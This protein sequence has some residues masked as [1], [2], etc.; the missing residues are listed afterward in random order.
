[1]NVVAAASAITVPVSVPSRTRLTEFSQ[2]GGCG[3]KIEPA[4]LRQILSNVPKRCDNEAL[5][6]GLE[7]SDDAAVYRISPSQALVF[8]NDFQSPIVDDPYQFGWIAAANAL[9]DVY[10]M[11]GA[12]LLANAIVGYPSG[13]ID[14]PV[15]QEIMR[16]GVEACK[17]AGIPLA[18]GHTINN[19]Q[20]LYGLAVV[21]MLHP[22]CVKTN[23]GARAGDVLLITKPLG[24]GIMSTAIKTGDLSDEGYEQFLQQARAI[25]LA[26]AWL[27]QQRAVHALTDITGFGL[28]GHLIEMAKGARVDMRIN[29]AAV[30]VMDEAWTLVTRGIVPSGAYRNMQSYGDQVSFADGWDMDAQ[31]VFTDPQTNGGLLVSVAAAE[32]DK[33]IAGLHEQGCQQVTV[34][35]EVVARRGTDAPVAFV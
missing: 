6:V 33:I 30:P 2:G 19:P 31:L 26:G 1:M 23:A 21:G 15:V 8:T 5:L 25:N 16:G 28:A 11:G 4:T 12:P 3:C 22:D 14:V 27:G 32:A 35:G 29:A 9:S 7:N 20:P 24:I 13:K 18:G 34:I 10:A 17:A